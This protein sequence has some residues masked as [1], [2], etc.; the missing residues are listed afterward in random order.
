MANPITLS[1]DC[2]GGGIKATALNALGTIIAPAVRTVTPYPL[3]PQLLIDTI[4][5]LASSLPQPDRIT[6]GMPGMVRHGV[7][8]A[9]PHYVT[10]AGP[11]TRVLPELVDQ[12]SGFDIR[13]QLSH[14]LEVPVLVLNDAEVHG[15]GVIAGTGLELIFTLGTGL[16]SAMFDAGR[17][18]PHIELSQAPLRWGLTYDDYL[19][20]HERLRL[21][22]AHWSRRVRNV[23]EALRPVFLWDRLYLGGGN[24]RRINP[25]TLTRLGDDVVIVPN[26]AGI[27]GGV[28]AWEL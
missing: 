22:D 6:V 27:L 2:G 13:R 5:G 19:G 23:V 1:V 28:R 21:G 18:A 14:T 26:S 10:K 7:V 25:T 8:I 9:T 11:R 17:L 24:S 16:G 20:E 3:P 15:A 4:E 12:W